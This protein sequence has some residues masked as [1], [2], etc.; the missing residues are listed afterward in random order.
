MTL[1][2]FD[3]DGVLVDSEVIAHQTLLDSIAPLGLTM[4]QVPSS[5]WFVNLVASMMRGDRETLGLFA[6]NPFPDRPPRFVRALYYQYQFTTPEEH[7]RTGN[8]WTRRLVGTFFG[9]VSL[10]QL[11]PVSEF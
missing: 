5:R 1:L 8:W 10:S 3:C 4:S 2:I 6:R 9:P 7:R 11:Q